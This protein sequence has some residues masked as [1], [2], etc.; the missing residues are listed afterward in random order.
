M[1]PRGGISIAVHHSAS[2]GYLEDHRLLRAFAESKHGRRFG[3]T[4]LQRCGLDAAED[5]AQI[6]Q[7][8]WHVSV[9]NVTGI[10]PAGGELRGIHKIVQRAASAAL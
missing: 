2:D 9:I 1:L 6:V 8:F 5:E 7:D 3:E 4:A 10:K